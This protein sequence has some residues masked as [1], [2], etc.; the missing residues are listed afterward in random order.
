MALEAARQIGIIEK[1]QGCVLQLND[2]NFL[3]ELPLPD[4]SGDD[5]CIETHFNLKRIGD[6]PEFRFDI[7][8][9]TSNED[10]AQYCLGMIRFA[11][12]PVEGIVKTAER[13]T[14]EAMFVEH[15][16]SIGFHPHV[17][18][19]SLHLGP[20]H[21][22]GQFASTKLDDEEYCLD[23][24]SFSSL[25][26]LP[27]MMMLGYS[28]PAIHRLESLDSLEVL[29]DVWNLQS[30]NFNV[31]VERNGPIQG[32]ANLQIYNVA[33]H[34]MNFRGMH[35]SRCEFLKRRPP[36][37][38]LF[39]RPE[40]LP[41]I[42][43]LE[44]SESYTLVLSR[45]IEFVTHKWPMSDIGISGLSTTD[46]SII[47]SNLKGIDVCDRPRF[48]SLNIVSTAAVSNSGR[49]R[50]LNEFG[51]EHEFHLLFSSTEA[52]PRI[53]CRIRR[54]GIVC[55]RAHDLSD[56][57]LF[58]ES[59][60]L[61][62]RVD[63][64]ESDGWLLGR[65]K[66]LQNRAA[67]PRKVKMFASQDC[68]KIC[69][70]MDRNF[71]Y[72]ELGAKIKEKEN[73]PREPFDLIVLDCGE[74]S[75]LT[76]WAGEDF[77]PPIQTEVEQ[78]ENLLW[79]T[80]QAEPTPFSK[81][82]GGFI[83]TIQSEHPS[84]KAV[85]LHI[86]GECDPS[87]LRE[88]ILKVYDDI[89][90]GSTEVELVMKDLQLYI[91]RYQPDDE[92]SAAVGTISPH[93]SSQCLGSN[94]YEV[95]LATPGNPIL[96]SQRFHEHF[97]ADSTDL[98]VSVEASVIDHRDARLFVGHY[99]KELTWQGLGQFFAGYVMSDKNDTNEK[100]TCVFGWCLGAHKSEILVH[101]CHV[102]N[103]PQGMLPADAAVHYAAH[104]T[105]LAIIHG[106]ARARPKETFGIRLSGLLAEALT[107]I[108]HLLG[109]LPILD[110]SKDVDFVVTFDRVHGLLLDGKE[111]SI[112]KYMLSDLHQHYMRTLWIKTPF[113]KTSLRIWELKDL[114]IA[115]Q[116]AETDQISGVLL[117][118]GTSQIRNHILDYKPPK[119]LFKGDAIYI[120]AGGLGGLGRF[121]SPWMVT[122]GARHLVVLCRSGGTSSEARN[123]I[124][125]VQDLGAEMQVFQ[126]DLRDAQAVRSIICKVRKIRPIRGCI[127]MVLALGNSPFL[128]MNPTQW[129]IP[130]R[131]KVDSSWNLHEATL[132]DELDI[133][134]M[135]SSVSSISGN[136]TQ[137]NYA[138][139]N[140]FQ[141]SMAQYRRALS[142]PAIAIAL[143]AM[144]EIGVLAEDKALLRT[145]TR[146][147]LLILGPLDLLKVLEAAVV[148]SLHSDRTLLSVGF[149]MFESIDNVIQSAPEQ[150]QLFWTES[151]EFGFLLDYKCSRTG[152]S[153][154]VSLKERLMAQEADMR[155]HDTLLEEFLR[156]LG[157][158]LGYDATILDPDLSL[159]SHGLD[160]LNAVA[161]RYWFF[162]RA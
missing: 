52:L 35:I 154:I 84:M 8:A 71:E 147:G 105:A 161:C 80:K 68:Y 33:G 160:S 62:G 64:F 98:C 2:V 83:R 120:L 143:G 144:S 19:K 67:S 102:F 109:V 79:I 145:L 149:E 129:D 90:D 101:S 47:C 123:T 142:M 137:S 49:I 26:E 55:V 48:R 124:Q 148:E 27:N 86:E 106:C 89:I 112:L 93:V 32:E 119:R 70:D 139:G 95:S 45:A 75:I 4:L 22:A 134:I 136:R 126:T 18:I 155:P 21:A 77:L 37:K 73:Q 91:L 3:K 130:L 1:A 41:D 56:R 135:F 14:H 82:A 146:S 132:S 99:S 100:A 6:S 30:G 54:S 51:Q 20:Y 50:T 58:N 17:N 7:L 40:L 9:S 110:P 122:H 81:V 128:K 29:V 11:S 97:I 46:T 44:P 72:T 127:N 85:N 152:V 66:H 133:F 63:G 157:D 12:P 16:E 116:N 36:L 59:F 88:S 156:F 140:C 15:L 92:L 104:C 28:I 115:F 121:I 57:T 151:P 138:T 25:L 76:T 114:Y 34:Q 10:W 42:T 111:V 162:K 39:F 13:P 60:D 150:N 125:A 141:N 131:T 31:H 43:L 159:A 69:Q 61:I 23:P 87:R 65:R 108:C 96:L 53:A 107:N 118:K 78:V 74:R 24:T 153:K 38:S 113:L 103:A 94:Y 117:H 5:N 158:M